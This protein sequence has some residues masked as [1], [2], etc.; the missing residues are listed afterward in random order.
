MPDQHAISHQEKTAIFFF[1]RTDTHD[2]F[3]NDDRNHAFDN[4]YTTA[5]MSRATNQFWY[6]LLFTRR[7]L[8]NRGV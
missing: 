5:C 8:G 7:A 4:N 1:F 3:D 2:D 6:T